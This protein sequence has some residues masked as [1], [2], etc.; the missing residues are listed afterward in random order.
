MMAFGLE[1]Q[2]RPPENPLY[3]HVNQL[4]IMT[5]LPSLTTMSIDFIIQTQ[6]N[7]QVDKHNYEYKYEVLMFDPMAMAI[8]ARN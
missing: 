1:T 8:K 5:L 2:N 7:E 3:V 4:D 6:F